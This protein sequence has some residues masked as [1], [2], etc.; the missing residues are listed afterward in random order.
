MADPADTQASLEASLEGE[1]LHKPIESGAR[2]VSQR[3]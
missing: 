1:I 2:M 3:V